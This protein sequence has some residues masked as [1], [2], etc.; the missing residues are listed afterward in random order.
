VDA[1]G[2]S[3][4]SEAEDLPDQGEPTKGAHSSGATPI[5]ECPPWVTGGLEAYVGEAP[6]VAA[7]SLVVKA[8]ADT[9]PASAM[10]VGI[11]NFGPTARS[12]DM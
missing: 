9:N 10:A 4:V 6:C 8:A 5:V 1:R 12:L 2:L 11:R 3:P 7:T